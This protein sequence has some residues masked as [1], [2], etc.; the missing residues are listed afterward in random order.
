MVTVARTAPGI[1]AIRPIN[2]PVP[3]RVAI[4]SS[5]WPT[6]LF[7]NRGKL[8]IA[9]VNDAWRIVDEWWRDLP[10][11]RTYFEVYIVDGRRFVLFQDHVSGRWFRQY[12]D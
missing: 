3:L 6:A 7:S 1:C 11:V 10:V 2:A 4:N 8:N 12:Y 5:G 9:R